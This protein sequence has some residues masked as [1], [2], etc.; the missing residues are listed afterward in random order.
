M[1]ITRN[2]VQFG[3]PRASGDDCH[4]TIE[5]QL[6]YCS[7]AGLTGA[8]ILWQRDLWAILFAQKVLDL[9]EPGSMANRRRAQ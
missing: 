6:A 5:T 4:E 3:S 9:S 2:V 1:W 7:A 8:R